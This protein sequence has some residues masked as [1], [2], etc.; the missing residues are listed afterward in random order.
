MLDR[1]SFCYTGEKKFSC[2]ECDKKFMRSD[3]L[4]KHM[5]THKK[6]FVPVVT[7]VSGG[8]EGLQGKVYAGLYHAIQ[9]NVFSLVIDNLAY[10]AF[11]V[12]YVTVNLF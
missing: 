9:P 10:A 6:D 11:S 8:D 1:F 4:T 12:D 5:R 2:A 3:H 7:T